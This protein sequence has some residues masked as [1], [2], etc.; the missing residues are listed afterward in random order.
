MSDNIG[1]EEQVEFKGTCLDC[2]LI[3][4]E[5]KELS[6]QLN[7]LRKENED[8]KDHHDTAKRTLNG[9][10]RNLEETER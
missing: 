3:Y 2:Y 1:N 6:K 5:N 10:S 9:L 4:K 7:Y 8:L